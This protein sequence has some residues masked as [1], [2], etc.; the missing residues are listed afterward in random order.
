VEANTNTAALYPRL[1]AAIDTVL[2][3]HLVELSRHASVGVASGYELRTLAVGFVDVVGSSALAL[4]MSLGDIGTSMQRFDTHAADTVTARGGRVVKFIGDEVMYQ[5]ADPESACETALDIVDAYRDDDVL[6][7]A[8]AGVAFG[9]VLV[10]DGDCF[11]PVVNLAARATK[12]ARP[13]AVLVTDELARAVTGS[14]LQ[15]TPLRPRQVKG[16]DDPVLL[17][18]VD[19]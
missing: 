10:R 17:V 11:G 2:R 1:L 19:R 9:D 7:G 14:G 4:H 3:Q 5:M 13:H 16:F 6:P 12:Y 15:F 18:R 8:R